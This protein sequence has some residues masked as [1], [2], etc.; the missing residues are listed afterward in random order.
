MW[1]AAKSLRSCDSLSS[2]PS[3]ILKQ[4]KIRRDEKSNSCCIVYLLKPRVIVWRATRCLRPCDRLSSAPSVMLL[5][6]RIKRSE[7]S[8]SC[9][10]LPTKVKSDRLESCKVSNAL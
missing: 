3:V 6:L 5:Q 10:S 7:T 8:N 1:R 4:L 2:P 9:Y